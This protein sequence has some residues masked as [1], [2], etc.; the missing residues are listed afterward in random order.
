[1][2]PSLFSHFPVLAVDK[3]LDPQHERKMDEVRGDGERM[4]RK[5]NEKAKK[6]NE[7][8]RE[9]EELS[10]KTRKTTTTTNNEVQVPGASFRHL[11]FLPL[12]N[13][14]GD[15][16]FYTFFSSTPEIPI[17]FCNSTIVNFFS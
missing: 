3:T 4:K 11:N 15:L 2:K 12:Y 1:M 5:G 9:C 6:K 8:W 13:Q 14:I 16:N 7:L 17:F 10:D